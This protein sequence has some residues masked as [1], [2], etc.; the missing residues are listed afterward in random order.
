MLS[1]DEQRASF[2]V[3]ELSLLPPDRIER[4]TPKPGSGR[5]CGCFHCRREWRRIAAVSVEVLEQGVDPLDRE[6][7]L[8]YAASSLSGDRDR[9]C[10]CSL[11]SDP[12]VVSPGEEVFTNGRHRT[13]AMR[14][15]GVERAAI[16]TKAGER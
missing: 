15:A 3:V 2:E 14:M 11:F 4:E 9:L 7:V 1:D 8:A 16:Y 6:A 5:T 10:L 12:I 13:H